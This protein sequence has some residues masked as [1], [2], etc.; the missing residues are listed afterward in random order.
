M[1]AMANRLE[2]LITTLNARPPILVYHGTGTQ[3]YTVAPPANFTIDTEVFDSGTVG[4]V[5]SAVL[6]IPSTGLYVLV[7]QAST[8]AGVS[9]IAPTSSTAGSLAQ[10]TVSTA[11]GNASNTVYLT[12]G[13]T[14]TLTI[15]AIDA[16]TITFD[17]KLY[18]IA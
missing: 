1:L 14:I 18:R 7:I 9:N 15:A 10:R 11:G 6:T 3:S 5:G 13:G 17:V 12:S 4:A 8:S 2:T 16:S